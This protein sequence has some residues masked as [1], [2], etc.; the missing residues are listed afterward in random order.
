MTIIQKICNTINVNSRIATALFLGHMS[1]LNRED[2]KKLR[3]R[4][5]KEGA[6]EFICQN[7]KNFAWSDE[8]KNSFPMGNEETHWFWKFW[9]D[10]YEP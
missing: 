1:E 4:L 10:Y 8:D 5:E 6:F 7:Y 3:K 2:M 9:Y